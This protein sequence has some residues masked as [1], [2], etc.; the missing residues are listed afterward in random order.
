MHRGASGPVNG[1]IVGIERREG[2]A[3]DLPGESADFFRGRTVFET[4]RGES[5][6]VE[7]V[8][9]MM[10]LGLQLPPF[11]RQGLTDLRLEIL[12]KLETLFESCLAV[13]QK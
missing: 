2:W 5:E 10:G 7:G 11:K 3:G 13:V 1:Q 9:R 4:P 8:E 6:R 12:E